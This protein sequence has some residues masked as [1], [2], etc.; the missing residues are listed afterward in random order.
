MSNET[1]TNNTTANATVKDPNSRMVTIKM[2]LND[3]KELRVRAAQEDRSIS[4]VASE[5]II[6][7][8]KASAPKA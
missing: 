6:K 1:T 2:T 5:Y 4:E 7:G 3:H 8:L